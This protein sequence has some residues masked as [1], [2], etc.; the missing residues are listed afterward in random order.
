VG[1]VWIPDQCTLPTVEQPTRVAE[2]RL[3]LTRSIR[4]ARRPSPCELRLLL[5]ASAVADARKLCG[6]ESQCCSFFSFY[7]EAAEDGTVLIVRVPPQY[8]EVL[9]RLEAP[10]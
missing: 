6:R 3:L 1:E 7:F 5:D 9:D 2:F 10:S 8:S 4:S